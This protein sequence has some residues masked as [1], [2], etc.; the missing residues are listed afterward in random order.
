MGSLFFG[1]KESI[2]ESAGLTNIFIATSHKTIII[3]NIG[4][5]GAKI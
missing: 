5:N 1:A 2:I 3:G 4:S